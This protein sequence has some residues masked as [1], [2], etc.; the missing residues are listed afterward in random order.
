[1]SR[2]RQTSLRSWHE[3]LRGH[4]RWLI[5]AVIVVLVA[6]FT[7]YS[8]AETYRLEVKEYTY[9]SPDVPP[10]FDG[11]R[12]ALLTDIHRSFYFSQE[13]VGAVVDRVNQLTPDLIVLG[14]DYVYGDKRY[15]SSAFVEL[16]RLSAPLGTFAV[17]GNHDYEHAGG[18]NDPGPALRAMADAKITILDN[19][20]VWVESD[21]QRFRLGGVSDL[22]QAYPEAA[23]TVAETGP[24]DLVLLVSHAPDFAETLLPGTVDL[25]LS[26]HTH[27]GQITLF[28]LWAPTT[29]S[30]YGQ[31]YRTGMVSS[32]A[33]TVV[34]SNGV[35]SIF[36]PLRF[37]ARPQIVVIT[38]EAAP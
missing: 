29:R 37:F 31:R 35:G 22:E 17:L 32:A 11:M 26:G 27:G 30:N 5:V 20:A 9:T 1:L 24:D 25:V 14:G 21:G 18:S 16:G 23:P 38:L 36:P 15:E 13:R 2:G 3:R 8:F 34:V 12:I 6:A 10:A 7:G 33:T 28:G 19:D 4:K